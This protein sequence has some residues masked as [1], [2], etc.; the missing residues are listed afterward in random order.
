DGTLLRWEDNLQFWQVLHRIIEA[1]PALNEFQPMY[2]QLI[3]LGIEKGKPF[4]PDTRMRDILERAAKA[5]SDQML[6]SAF[7]S[8]RAE[9][10]AWPDRKW[11]WAGLISDNGS[12]Q[13]SAGPDL[14]ARYRWFAQAILT[15]P[16]MFRRSAGAGSLYWL[17][18]RDKS[19]AYLDG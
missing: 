15:S 10:F 4:A 12:F 13:T 5:G 17:G 2:G 14:E 18:L 8:G 19:G 11:E 3:A 1:E 16:A 9:R 7:D 6:V